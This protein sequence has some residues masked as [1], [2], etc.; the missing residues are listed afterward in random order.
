MSDYIFWCFVQ[1]DNTLFPVETS[2]DISIGEMKALIMKKK[3]N[4]L[5][6]FDAL[7]LN[8]SKVRD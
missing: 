4:F 8:L 3:E 6:G 1:G 7:S 5:Q 2:L